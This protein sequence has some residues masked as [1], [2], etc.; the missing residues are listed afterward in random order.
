MV[1]QKQYHSFYELGLHDRSSY[2]D[3]RLVRKYDA[4]FRYGPYITLE[5]EISKILEE[6][7]IEYFLFSQIFDIF[8]CKFQVLKYSITCS[9]PA[10]IA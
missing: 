7:F 3:Q 9:S 1:D 2:C 6:L 4:S 10:K 8:I 5:F